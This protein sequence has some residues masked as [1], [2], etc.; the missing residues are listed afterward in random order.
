MKNGSNEH[1]GLKVEGTAL[2][3]FWV[4][5]GHNVLEAILDFFNNAS[6]SVAT[7]DNSP[8]PAPLKAVLFASW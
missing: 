5:G 6:V 1:L 8:F 7:N 3:S 2:V 4:H